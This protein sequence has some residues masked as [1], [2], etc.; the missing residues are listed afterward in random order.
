MNKGDRARL[1]GL[2]TGEGL[3]R[4]LIGREGTITYCKTYDMRGIGSPTFYSILLDPFP[5]ERAKKEVN[6]LPES[7]LEKL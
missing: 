4:K 7:K 6:N 1:M 2:P 5:G 3:S